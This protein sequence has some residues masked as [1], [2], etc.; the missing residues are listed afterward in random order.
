MATRDYASEWARADEAGR[1]AVEALAVEPMT[2]VGGGKVYHVEGGACGF[3][4]V[5]FPGNSG[6]GRWAKAEGHASKAYGGGLMFWI[7]GYGQSMQRK[8][9][10][11][12]AFAYSLMMDGIDG[13]RVESMM[14]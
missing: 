11:A 2:V 6:F 8:V 4:S 9:A 13:V 10:Y 3:A 5:R 14:D 12:N 1:K 7:S